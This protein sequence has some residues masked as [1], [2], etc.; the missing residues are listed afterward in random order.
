MRIGV[1]GV[2]HL[3]SVIITRLVE[4]GWPTDRLVLSSRGKGP[5][6]AARYGLRLVLD[7][8][9]LVNEATT[10]LLAVRPPAAEEAVQG[11][12]WRQNHIIVSTCAGVSIARLR[13]AAGEAP[14]IMRVMPLTA[15]ELGASP[16]TVYPD[17][18]EARSL[19]KPLGPVLPMPS[20]E[21]FETATVTAA[22]YGWA[23]HL[24][25][26]TSGWLA[27]HGIEP[28]VA[29]RLS[30]LTFVA[31]GRLTAESPTDLDD[32]MRGLVTP[33]GITELG[34]KTLEQKGAPAAW[35]AACDAVLARLQG[36]RTG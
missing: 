19:L 9:A 28:Q 18:P 32:L 4:S 11:L 27:A 35:D 20:E 13:A 8:A 1:L 30:A 24:V 31:A 21:A 22:V 34:Q 29:R 6:I 25:R 5:E 26:Q 2:G 3:A 15:A 7:N 36:K 17:L 23:Q 12:R 33:G 16:T 14:R 10:I